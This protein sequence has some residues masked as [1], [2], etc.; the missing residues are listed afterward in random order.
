MKAGSARVL[1]IWGM[2][3][4]KAKDDSKK[5]SRLLM[6]PERGQVT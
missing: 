1:Y 2:Q 5:T 6:G 4:I 3:A